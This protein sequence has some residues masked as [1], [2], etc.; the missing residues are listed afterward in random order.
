MTV[1]D[2]GHCGVDDFVTFSPT[3]LGGEVTASAFKCG[4][5]MQKIVNN[6]VY[7]YVGE[8]LQIARTRQ[9]ALRE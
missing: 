5:Q 4:N 2:A 7:E 9:T 1:T 6:D 3:G 8:T